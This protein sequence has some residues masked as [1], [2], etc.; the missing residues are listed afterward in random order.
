MAYSPA[1]LAVGLAVAFW[2]ILVPMVRGR[3]A[4]LR[5][6]VLFV[7]LLA[8]AAYHRHGVSNDPYMV[9]GV[10]AGALS[11]G[12]VYLR[13][14]LVGLAWLYLAASLVWF[15]WSVL[16]FAHHADENVFS[17]F[18]ILGLVAWAAQIVI[19]ARILKY[20]GDPLGLY[21]GY[22]Q[23]EDWFTWDLKQKSARD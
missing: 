12:Y 11:W 9:L 23:P 19:Y 15:A 21:K 22:R 6:S 17:W 1:Y 7:Y 18:V 16:L 8:G 13:N 2:G 10:V 5:S 20:S 14:N 4:D 3:S